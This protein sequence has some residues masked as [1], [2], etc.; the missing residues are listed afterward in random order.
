MILPLDAAKLL[1]LELCYKVTKNT[2]M[3]QMLC[4]AKNCKRLAKSNTKRFKNKRERDRL[5]IIYLFVTL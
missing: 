2:K 1:S 3:L 5:Y 4:N